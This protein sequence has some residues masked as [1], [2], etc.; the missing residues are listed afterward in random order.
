MFLRIVRRFVVLAVVLTV[1]TPCALAAE[2]R[3]RPGVRGA[4]RTAEHFLSGLW[5]QLT[6][7]W[8]K[9][10]AH[11]DPNGITT[12]AEGENGPHAD[13]YGQTTSGE[14]GAHADPDGAP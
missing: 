7:L 2:T 9:N 4:H 6:S 14:N 11:A 3:V 13:P 12:S 8:A 10:G 5:A 1:P